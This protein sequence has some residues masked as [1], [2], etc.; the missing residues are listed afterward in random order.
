MRMPNGLGAFHIIGIGGIGMS[1]IAEVL[2]DRG[3]V[4]R[5]SDL[6]PGA[7]I[8]RLRAK[9]I[10]CAIG[11]DPGNVGDASFVVASTAVKADNPELEAARERSIP[12]IRRAEMLAE[13]MRECATISVTGTHGKTTTTSLISELL[14]HAELDPTVLSGGIINSIGS[15]ARIGRGEWL[16][17]EADESDGTFTRLPTRIGVVTNIDPEHMDY[18]QTIEALHRAFR[19]FFEGIPFYGLI[20]AGV[21]H[22]IVRE[23]VAGIRREQTCRRVLTYGAADDADIR[24]ANMRAEGGGVI[25]D[26][27]LSAKVPGGER[28]LRDLRLAVPGQYNALNALAAIAVGTEIGINDADIRSSFAGFGGVQRRFTPCGEWNGVTVFDDYAHHPVEISA[29][30]K[31]ARDATD[32]SVI[33]VV[34]PHRYTRLKNLFGDFCTCFADADTV[35]VTPVYTAGES[36]IEGADRDA[37]IDGLGRQGHEHVL[38]TESFETLVPQIA[39]IAKPGDLVIGLGAGTITDWARDLPD[40]LEGQAPTR[41][42]A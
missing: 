26:A 32:G 35:I 30:L 22:P 3:Y 1:A 27:E 8:E 25:F 15:N 5:G 14:M 13:L 23:M 18:W 31:A 17:V 10:E 40:A 39:A 42:R 33:A 28:A 41:A 6:K 21:D 29:V 7:N 38:A 19:K 9:G 24:L 12:I 4:V 20:V 34:Q 36:P 11:H 2:H 37:L 16:V